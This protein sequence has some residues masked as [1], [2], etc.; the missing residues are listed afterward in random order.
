MIVVYWKVDAVIHRDEDSEVEEA[1]A[2]SRRRFL[3]N[4]DVHDGR[5][6]A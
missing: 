2:K 6:H 5:F 1:G 3:L 4:T